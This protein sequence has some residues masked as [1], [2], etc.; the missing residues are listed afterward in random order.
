MTL[1]NST[2]ALLLRTAKTAMVAAIAVLFSIIAFGN[3]TD[4]GTN[5][6]FVQ[7]VMSMDT[8]FP[9]TMI[10]YRAITSPLVHHIAYNV[11]IATEILI[12]L[13]C[14]LGALALLRSLRAPAERFRRAKSLAIAGLALGF[15]L[16]QFGFIT[17]GGEWFGM[18]MSQHWNGVQDAFH[19]LMITIAVLIFVTMPEGD[20]AS[21]E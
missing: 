8:L 14:W 15:L 19:Y 21:A 13:L 1:L 7:H 10:T 18:W 12:A 11:I 9:T 20:I 2:P 3:I 4:Y 6:A 5:F 17:I 16:Y